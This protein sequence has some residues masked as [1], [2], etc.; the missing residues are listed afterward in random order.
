MKKL[1]AWSDSAC[2]ATGFGTVS[3]HVLSALHASG[4]FQIEQIGINHHCEFY[5]QQEV[6]WQIHP[7]K[8]FDPK[9]PFGRSLFL[10]IFR[11]REYDFVWILNDWQILC[12]VLKEINNIKNNKIK[13]SEKYPKI[14]FYF[15]ID[16]ELAE[17]NDV[18]FDVFDKVVL[19]CDFGFKQILKMSPMA[20]EKLSIINHGVDFSYMRRLPAEERRQIRQNL[21]DINS[22]ETFLILNVNRNT[23]RKQLPLTIL[24]Y[25]EFRKFIT[26]SK[27]YLHT[28]FYDS[29][30][31][32]NL[33][34]ATRQLGL[35]T[36][37]E[38]IYPVGFDIS[39]PAAREQLNQIYNAADCFLTTS[40]GEGWGLTHTDAMAVYLPV[41]APD[42]TC[43]PEQLDCG[44]RGFIYPCKSKVWVDGGGYRP[45]PEVKDIVSKLLEVHELKKNLRINK[46]DIT[47]APQIKAAR[48][49]VA[50][51][52][53]DKIC[54]QW[55]E[56]FRSLL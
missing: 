5:N 20:K 14:I 24:A 52:S 23:L 44:S 6:P 15:P 22:D 46:L 26:D 10:K 42:N 28:S 4:E 48:D 54:G 49:Y 51:L 31:G 27:L 17:E 40:L 7:A 33:S 11:E 35:S 30:S 34:A 25:H 53:W 16:T 50:D 39:N 37:N 43:F 12:S 36:T 9:D 47:S 18:F 19:Y 45:Y 13:L 55:L 3:R 56:L 38:V 32:I 8:Y 21:F 1:L 41:I 29:L 2:T